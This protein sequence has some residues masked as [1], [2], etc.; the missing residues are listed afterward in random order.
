[1]CNIVQFLGESTFNIYHWPNG[2]CFKLLR[3]FVY[4]ILLLAHNCFGNHVGNFFQ[5]ISQC[6]IWST[7]F[8][9]IHH[10]N[11]NWPNFFG[12]HAFGRSELKCFQWRLTK[13]HSVNTGPTKMGGW[14]KEERVSNYTVLFGSTKSF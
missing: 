5:S 6:S 11:D 1:M 4:P 7:R 3:H 13:S 2:R 12:D 10:E 9:S 8:W 14:G